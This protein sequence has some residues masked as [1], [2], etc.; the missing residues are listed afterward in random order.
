MKGNKTMKTTTS[1]TYPAFALFVLACFALSPRAFATGEPTFTPN[2]YS[3][4]NRSVNVT[5]RST[6]SGG[7]IFVESS[8]DNG[9]TWDPAGFWIANGGT[10]TVSFGTGSEKLRAKHGSTAHVFDSNWGFSGTYKYLCP[11]PSPSPKAKIVLVIGVILLVALLI[12]L[13]V[14]KSSANR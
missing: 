9:A 4:C 6:S 10:T 12:W 11:G 3:G 5:F 13:F 8:T 14:K 2:S 1:F 7:L